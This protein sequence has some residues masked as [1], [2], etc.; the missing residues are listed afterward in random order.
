MEW[1]VNGEKFGNHYL[2]GTAPHSLE[3][4]QRWLG[5]IAALPRAFDA[6]KVAK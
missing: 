5:Q 3:R 4:Y 1:E 6:A 2:S